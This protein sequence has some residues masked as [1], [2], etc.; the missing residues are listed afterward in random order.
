[1]TTI[2]KNILCK[3]L[4]Y[5][6]NQINAEEMANFIMNEFEK[7]EK[8]EIIIVNIGTDKCVGDSFGPFLGSYLED[9]NYSM[10]VYGTLEKPIHALNMQEN[11]DKIKD[12]HENP[13]IISL[14]SALS[15]SN[16]IGNVIIR[17][18]PVEAGAGVGKE[19]PSVGDVSIIYNAC[20]I[21][22]GFYGLMN[23]VRIGSILKVVKETY[24]IFTELEKVY[25]LYN[26]DLKNII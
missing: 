2:D 25:D 8:E 22:L 1:M 6:N 21:D 4:E 15:S 9:K 5:K 16:D 3:R 14:D 7:S 13:F 12:I 24:N 10:K 18:K 17:N 19:L 20:D 11:L 23:N 26:I